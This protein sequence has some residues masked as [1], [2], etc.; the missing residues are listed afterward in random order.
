MECLMAE[1]AA[2]SGARGHTIYKHIHV[3]D[4]GEAMLIRFSGYER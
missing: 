3:L 1:K 4:L 2:E